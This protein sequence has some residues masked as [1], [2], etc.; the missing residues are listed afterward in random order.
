MKSLSLIVS[1]SIV[2]LMSMPANAQNQ[3]DYEALCRN[4][5][6]Y[7]FSQ[8]ECDRWIREQNQRSP[9]N[10]SGNGRS[11]VNSA[12]IGEK[13]YKMRLRD[14]P[15]GNIGQQSIF[16]PGDLDREEW[17]VVT[18][19]NNQRIKV[20]HAT[21]VMNKFWGTRKWYDHPATAIRLC[22]IDGFDTSDCV[23]AQGDTIDL[24][25]GKTINDVQIDF[26]YVEG[27][28]VYTRTVQIAP[29][30]LPD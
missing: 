11:A 17:V 15:T 13:V 27:G 14:A 20:R 23:T 22:A 5:E 2:C 4:R 3:T 8:E 30:T 24:P 9:T 19:I 12:F 21:N 6:S 29:G 26:K 18:L 25:E 1:G 7:G 28:S 16:S 10:S